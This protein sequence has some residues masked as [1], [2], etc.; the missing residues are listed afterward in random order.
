MKPSTYI[1]FN[2]ERLTFS[3]SLWN[4]PCI[5]E[6]QHFKGKKGESNSSVFKVGALEKYSHLS[7]MSKKIKTKHQQKKHC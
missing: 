5:I 7:D 2:R 3:K 4:T 6:M 1:I